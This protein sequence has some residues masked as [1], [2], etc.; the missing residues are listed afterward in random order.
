MESTFFPLT[1]H[2]LKEYVL[3]IRFNFD[4]YGR[5][6]NKVQ[7]YALFKVFDVL[8]RTLMKIEYILFFFNEFWPQKFGKF[9]CP[10][11]FLPNLAAPLQNYNLPLPL[12]ISGRSL[13]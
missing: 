4:N 13:K 11:W 6:L 12:M 5:S 9:G 8:I 7:I 2:P 3:F 10:F 1:S